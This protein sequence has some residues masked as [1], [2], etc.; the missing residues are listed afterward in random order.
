M[1]FV[2]QYAYWEELKYFTNQL[3]FFAVVWVR[4]LLRTC[5]IRNQFEIFRDRKAVSTA[6]RRHKSNKPYQSRLTRWADQLLP[7][8]YDT[9]HVPFEMA[10]HLSRN[11][12]FGTPSPGRLIMNLM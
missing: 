3:G 5:L 12:S 11:P 10:D 7:F 4:E 9:R 2:S 6:L 8:G 1:Y